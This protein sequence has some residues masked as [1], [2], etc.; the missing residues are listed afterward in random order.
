MTIFA[1]NGQR[2]VA[3]L[4]NSPSLISSGVAIVKR[5]SRSR[6]VN[7][8]GVIGVCAERSDSNNPTN[9]ASKL[10]ATHAWN[11]LLICVR[12]NRPSE[13]QCAK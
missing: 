2:T 10:R 13:L 1:D 5:S 7:S 9:R 8:G 4:P 11:F 3:L 6:R 12:G